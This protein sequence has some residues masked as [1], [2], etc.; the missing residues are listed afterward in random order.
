MPTQIITLTEAGIN[1]G[2]L[3]NL[4][5][6]ADCVNYTLL[7]GSSPVFLPSVGTTASVEIPSASGCIKLENNNE[8]CNNSVI[9]T[10]I[11]C[12][13]PTCFGEPFPWRTIG[14]DVYWSTTAGDACS[15]PSNSFNWTGN[16]SDFCSLTSVCGSEIEIVWGGYPNVVLSYGGYYKSFT[17]VTST[18]YEATSCCFPCP[19]TTTTLSPTTTTL[20]PTTTTLSPTTTTL[21][22][23]TTT[24][25]EPTTTTLAPTT[26]TLAPTTT[27]IAPTTTTTITPT[28]TTTQCA[29]VQSVVLNV[30]SGGTFDF[31]DCCGTPRSTNV[32]TGE[33]IVDYS[34][35]GCININTFAG[36]AEYTVVSYG[37]CCTPTCPTTTT[38]VA[39]TTTTT[40]APT[41]TTIAPTTTTVA[42][43]TTTVAPTT[44]T[45]QPPTV[46]EVELCGGGLGP[47][48]VTLGSGDTPSGIGQAF[49]ISGNS[50]AGFNGINCWTVLQNPATGTPDYTNL[51]FGSV[52]SNC[53]ACVPTTTT[54]TTIAPTTT[55]LSPTTTTL[56][57]TTTTVAPT[58][59]TA[60]P[61]TTTTL[62]GFC[63]TGDEF[64]CS[65]GNCVAGPVGIPL[66]DVNN[67]PNVGSYYLDTITGKIFLVTQKEIC[68]GERTIVNLIDESDVCSNLCP[69]PTT[70]TLAPTTTTL[71][72]TT[73]TVAPTTTTLAP[74]TTTTTQ[75]CVTSVSFEVDSA[76][77]VS[78]VDCCGNTITSF[79]GIGP[80]V[81]NDC[82]QNGSLVGAGATISFITYGST[83]CTCVTTST[84]TTLA[85]TTTTLSPTTTTVA[86]TTTTIAPTTTTTTATSVDIYI[87]N[88]SL[89]IPITDMT[90]NGVSVTWVSGG[91]PVNAGE[92]GNFTSTQL[93][94]KDVIIYYGGHISGQNITFTDSDNNVT[95]QDLN[96]GA[97]SF[98][99]TGATITGGT[100]IYVAAADGACI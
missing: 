25:L 20:S 63:F 81:I 95:C 35:D 32:G 77:N 55:T 79:F 88:A 92:N 22:P 19:T 85:P 70:T 89:D 34:T 68:V 2:P 64:T 56:A 58:T 84:T 53:E 12:S 13:C 37:S 48:L 45:T 51:A 14:K 28:T 47:F 42:P 16:S 74:T 24:T 94:T 97:G 41:T 30:T 23:T 73:T 11:S 54:T 3:Y 50:G 99:I 29:C 7:T 1:T 17:R 60:A 52:F 71:S 6:A 96:G 27:T 57:P 75:A 69:Q 49:K 21:S 82:L 87:S 44:T 36:T 26:T 33:Q 67:D 38:T 5:W 65:N 83:G 61:T 62:S 46:Y 72:P 98:T 66:R 18:R 91:F 78:Y 59:T 10:I 93:G 100:T 86:P 43:T 9:H 40:I 90:I 31:T 4:Y 15:N 8:D 76:G 80:Q 39:P